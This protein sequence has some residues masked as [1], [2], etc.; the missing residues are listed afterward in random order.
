MSNERISAIVVIRSIMK[1]ADGLEL[2]LSSG[3]SCRPAVSLCHS[4][5]SHGLLL[6]VWKVNYD[7]WFFNRL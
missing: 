7:L 2:R 1:A 4:N 5:H 3:T 6:V